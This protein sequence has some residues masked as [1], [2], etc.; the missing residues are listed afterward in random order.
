[1]TDPDWVPVAA[2]RPSGEKA[3]LNT[4]SVATEEVFNLQIRYR[5]KLRKSHIYMYMYEIYI[6]CTT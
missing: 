5:Y 3:Q 1:M 2:T 6:T 4:P